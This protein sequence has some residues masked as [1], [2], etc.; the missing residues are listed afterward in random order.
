[1]QIEQMSLDAKCLLQFRNNVRYNLA[2]QNDIT[3][4]YFGIIFKELFCN[5]NIF[6]KIYFCTK[7]VNLVDFKNGSYKNYKYYD[8]LKY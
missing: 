3:M 4:N 6:L 1:M 2:D 7:Y 8:D 5:W